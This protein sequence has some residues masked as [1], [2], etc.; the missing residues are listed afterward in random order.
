[1]FDIKSFVVFNP[2]HAIES[3]SGILQIGV[4]FPIFERGENR[5]KLPKSI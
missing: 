5:R 4:R 1:M 3:V 2:D